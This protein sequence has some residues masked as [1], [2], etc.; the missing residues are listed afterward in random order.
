[1]I[2]VLYPTDASLIDAYIFTYL[3]RLT[4]THGRDG[5]RPARLFTAHQMKIE[6]LKI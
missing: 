3:K 1:M 2:Y 4:D 6:S 5:A